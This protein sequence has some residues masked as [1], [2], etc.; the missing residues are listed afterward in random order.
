MRFQTKCSQ[1][2]Q[3]LWIIKMKTTRFRTY[4]VKI[5]HK[6]DWLKTN[7][8]KHP[9]RGVYSKRCSGNM[10]QIYGRTP[11]PKCDFIKLLCNFIEVTLRHGCSLV[12]L[13]HIFKTPFTKNTSGWL[14]L[15]IQCSTSMIHG[16][17]TLSRNPAKHNKHILSKIIPICET[18]SR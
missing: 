2:C 13:L 1:S 16:S 15:N 7:I 12:N 18:D 5:F 3:L 4:F 9:F 6:Q 14:L 17:R 11:M 8:Q 10:Q